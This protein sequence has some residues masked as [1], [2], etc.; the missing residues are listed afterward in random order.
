MND[1]RNG[2]NSKLREVV[3]LNVRGL[4]SSSEAMQDMLIRSLVEAIERE[5]VFV[6][7]VERSSTRRYDKKIAGAFKEYLSTCKPDF[8]E[9]QAES[10]QIQGLAKL[11]ERRE[12]KTPSGWICGYCEQGMTHEEYLQ[13]KC[14][15]SKQGY[16]LNT[17]LL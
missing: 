3:E 2:M 5:G 6:P 10:N 16:K 7:K 15:G 13:H 1:W 11:V 12:W 14:P 8:A 4:T 17:G 9:K